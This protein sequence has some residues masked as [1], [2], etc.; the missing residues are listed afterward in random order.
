MREILCFLYIIDSAKLR[1]NLRRSGLSFLNNLTILC[2][3]RCRFTGN[4]VG[5]A[6]ENYK[7]SLREVRMHLHRVQH[8]S[9]SLS[10]ELSKRTHAHVQLLQINACCIA[11]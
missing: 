6:G 5:E 8:V 10:R 9:I 2:M 11:V 7:E 3:L 1:L 4:A